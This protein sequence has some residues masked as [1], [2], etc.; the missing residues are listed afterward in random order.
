M[1]IDLKYQFDLEETL[2]KYIEKRDLSILEKA[3]KQMLLGIIVI[4]VRTYI[5]DER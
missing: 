2:R 3:P 4:L 5:G 1:G